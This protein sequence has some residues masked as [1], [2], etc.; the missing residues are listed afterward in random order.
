MRAVARNVRLDGLRF[1]RR[2][3][4]LCGLC[5]FG[6]L[7]RRKPEPSPYVIGYCA[8]IKTLGVR[9]GGLCHCRPHASVASL[10][11]QAKRGRNDEIVHCARFGGRCPHRRVPGPAEASRRRHAAGHVP[12]GAAVDAARGGRAA[13]VR[14]MRAV[15]RRPAPAGRHAAPSGG[16]PGRRG[17][18]RAHARAGRDGARHVGLRHRLRVGERPVGRPGCLRRRG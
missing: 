17:R 7:T 8:S 18:G 6:G 12:S 15:P 3:F 4:S 14:Q 2:P 16:L 11:K 13:N 1:G 5:L 9:W 10:H